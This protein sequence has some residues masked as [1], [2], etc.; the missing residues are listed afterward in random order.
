MQEGMSDGKNN[1]LLTSMVQKIVKMTPRSKLGAESVRGFVLPMGSQFSWRRQQL[2]MIA[3]KVIRFRA[4]WEQTTLQVLK[5]C[6][7]KH[8][9]DF[10]VIILMWS[11]FVPAFESSHTCN[12]FSH[13]GDIS[14]ITAFF[15][16][17]FWG[18][19]MDSYLLTPYK[20]SAIF[21]QMVNGGKSFKYLEAATSTLTF[22]PS[23][24]FYVT[25]ILC[26]YMVFMV[27]VHISKLTQTPILLS[28]LLYL[29]P[30]F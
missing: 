17:S 25:H 1:W 21:S 26:T 7:Y 6:S 11:S 2:H 23:F 8:R 3:Q 15:S 4:D 10:N 20:H 30:I 9:I 14:H 18:H 12:E 29:H 13:T 24:L 22:P 5:L 27:H 19:Y 16:C 28:K